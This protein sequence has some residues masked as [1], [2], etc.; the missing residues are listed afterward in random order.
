[1]MGGSPPSTSSQFKDF[2]AYLATLKGDLSNITAPPFLLSPTSV[3][4]IPSSWAK[5]QSLFLQPAQEDNAAHR[6]LLILKNF[7]CSLQHQ[8]KQPSKDASSST[9]PK[10]PLNAFLGEL[11]VGEFVSE[12]G[13]AT[14]LVSEQVSH[15]PPV[16]ASALYNRDH[17][18]SSAG[19]VA[20]ETTFHPVSGVRVQQTGYAIVR[21][22]KHAEAHLR[23]LPTL[24]VKG[25]LS[26]SLYPE[27]EGV[28]YVSSS[29]GYLS[30]VEFTGKSLGL[31]GGTKNSV[32]AELVN[33]REQGRRLFEVTGQWSGR[34]VIRDC[35]TGDVVE[36]FDVA[37]VPTAELRVRPIEEQSPWES[38][39]A[40]AGVAEGIRAGDMQRVYAA[41]TE[42]EE[43]QRE[44]RRAQEMTGVEWPT[45]FFCRTGENPEFEVLARAIPDPEAKE[46]KAERTGGVWEFVGAKTSEAL[47]AE[48]VYHESLEPTRQIVLDKAL[49]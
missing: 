3:T 30:T 1:M 32:R 48:G 27:L 22:E 39:R 38:R 35:A 17:G 5:H 43:A 14:R 36:D 6:A 31:G 46:L 37:D 12:D 26:G 23:T 2:I 41:K 10:K 7:L 11:F 4:E 21:D 20:Q 15:H 9:G 25:L 42:L 19:Y 34:L 28:C 44:I 29:S 33:V 13:S 40:W 16:T 8:L 49:N 45:M 24:S 47:I 18:I